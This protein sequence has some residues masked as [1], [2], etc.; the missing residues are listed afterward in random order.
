[1]KSIGLGV[2]FGFSALQISHNTDNDEATTPGFTG[3]DQLLKKPVELASM[4]YFFYKK[5]HK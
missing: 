3:T 2:N 4:E 5:K 1:M